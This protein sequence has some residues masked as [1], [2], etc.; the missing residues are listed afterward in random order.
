MNASLEKQL[1]DIAILEAD[2]DTLLRVIAD[3]KVK[4]ESHRIHK[5]RAV[6]LNELIAAKKAEFNHSLDQ[7]KVQTFKERGELP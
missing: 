1:D 4:H 7:F 6:E 2:L 5:S 3:E